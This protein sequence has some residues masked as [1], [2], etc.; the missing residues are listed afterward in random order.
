VIDGRR[1]R[2]NKSCIVPTKGKRGVRGGKEAEDEVK[3]W[4]SVV[5]VGGI[6]DGLLGIFLPGA[7]IHSSSQEPGARSVSD[8]ENSDAAESA[9]FGAALAKSGGSST[10]LTVGSGVGVGGLSTWVRLVGRRLGGNQGAFQGGIGCDEG[11]FF[12]RRCCKFSF[13]RVVSER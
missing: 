4:C 9:N 13:L 11:R 5:F 2:T 12:H 7:H 1:G 3:A 8:V 6:G 10:V